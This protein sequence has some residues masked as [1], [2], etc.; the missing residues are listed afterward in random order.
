M[1]VM[2]WLC[3][4]S[5]PHF[6]KTQMSCFAGVCAI[7]NHPPN[8]SARCT[9]VDLPSLSLGL[10]LSIS[11]PVMQHIAFP[12][13]IAPSQALHCLDATPGLLGLS[14]NFLPMGFFS[15]RNSFLCVGVQDKEEE[16]FARFCV[17]LFQEGCLLSFLHDKGMHLK[18]NP[19]L[20]REKK[21]YPG[22][23]QGLV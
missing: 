8:I 22:V 13:G 17:E 6:C 14:L 4:Q 15:F 1:M 21:K 16:A 23:L 18:K 7:K 10:S 2:I 3:A 5:F 9:L 11:T 12:R 19:I 20:L